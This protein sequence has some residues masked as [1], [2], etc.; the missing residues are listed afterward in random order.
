VGPAPSLRS[1]VSSNSNTKAR[2]CDGWVAT[3]QYCHL[4]STTW[5]SSNRGGRASWSQPRPARRH[6]HP[7]Q[8]KIWP[9]YFA[10]VLATGNRLHRLALSRCAWTGD[11][12]RGSRV[13]SS[14]QLPSASASASLARGPASCRSIWR[15]ACRMSVCGQ[16]IAR[17]YLLSAIWG[18]QPFSG[19]KSQAYTTP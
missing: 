3:N 7:R 9:P 10:P 2:K 6:H 4:L 12:R 17:S 19:Y 15:G 11:I 18:Q 14:C 1:M 13:V 5:L 8:I 16:P